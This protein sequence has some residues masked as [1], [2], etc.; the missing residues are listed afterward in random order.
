MIL[1]ITSFILLLRYLHGKFEPSPRPYGFANPAIFDNYGDDET[2]SV[3]LQER[4]NVAK[5][6]N[7]FLLLPYNPG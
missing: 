7:Q 2:K 3:Q 4:L 6:Q 1:T 5:V